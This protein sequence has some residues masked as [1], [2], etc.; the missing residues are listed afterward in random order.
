MRTHLLIPTILITLLLTNEGTVLAQSAPPPLPSPAPGPGIQPAGQ[1]SPSSAPTTLPQAGL[2]PATA[3]ST[4]ALPP[5]QQLEAVKPPEEESVPWYKHITLGAFAD[6]YAS[7]NY[8]F[9]KAAGNN[10]NLYHPYDAHQGFGLAWAGFD[11]AVDAGPVGAVIQ[12]RLG[13]AVQ[14]LALNDY[15]APGNI[16]NL[17]NAYLTWKP[18]G[19]DGN[20]TLVAG[21]FDTLYGAEVAVS[22]LNINYT[23]GAL[24]NL[25]QPFFHTGL[26]VDGVFGKVT[27]KLM[28]V[29]GWNNTIDNNR[30]KSFGAQLAYAPSDTATVSLGYLGGPEGSEFSAATSTPPLTEQPGA[31]T[32]WRHMVDLVADAKPTPNVRILANVTYVNDAVLDVN[33]TEQNVNWWGASL[34][35]RYG[36]ND[37]FGIGGRFEFIRDKNGQITSA[38]GVDMSLITGTLTLET[39]PTKY[40]VIRLDNRIDHTS[41]DVFANQGGI[42]TNRNQVTTTLGL[43]V[44]TP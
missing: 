41:E 39:T 20:I 30:M 6:T 28:V 37:Y 3:T 29:N 33:G 32:R 36:I 17:Q 4:P 23:R 2:A 42:G 38:P 9:P 7:V 25:A 18:Q 34:M 27:G 10:V 31:N 15:G 44:K 26:R 22:H 35:G 14:N 12:L 21:K 16:G 1:P 43:V 11:A 8:N 19:K 40:L 13:P 5:P 24:Y